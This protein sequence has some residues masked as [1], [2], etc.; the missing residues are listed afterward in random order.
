MWKGMIWGGLITGVMLLL[1]AYAWVK[2]PAGRQI[3]S[4][5][6]IDGQPD[7]YMG[8]TAALL[9]MPLLS[10]G[11]MALF[12]IIARLDPR[13]KHLEQS[14]RAYIAILTALLGLLA[15]AHGH[16]IAIALGMKVDILVVVPIALGVLFMIMGNYLGKIRSNFIAGIRTPWTLSSDLAWDKTHRFGGK[17]FMLVGLI[18]AF[19]VF[20]RNGFAFFTLLMSELILTSI[21]LSVYSY[22]VW[23]SDPDKRNGGPMSD[24]RAVRPVAVLTVVLT[25]ALAAAAFMLPRA[26]RP[27]VDVQPRAI[28]LVESMAGGNFTAAEQHFDRR[29]CAALPPAA[30]ES[31]WNG[32]VQQHGPFQRIAET[33]PG[34]CWPYFFVYVTARF[35]RAAVTMRVVFSRDGQ[36]SGLWL[37][38]VKPVTEGTK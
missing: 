36:I 22:L 2:I 8:K 13:R 31:L 19:S 34:G 25:L 5:W 38:G 24:G 28:A 6:G 29:M 11:L 1:S 12:L 35:E 23:R 30:L 10:L 3:A 20:L 4:H 17:I 32:L 16:I 27:S 21:M 9:V 7:G 37:V 15:V 14:S 18:I 33:R 26:M